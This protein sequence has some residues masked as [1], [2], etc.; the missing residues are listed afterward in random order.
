MQGARAAEGSADFITANRF[1]NM[2]HL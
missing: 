2:V 1:S